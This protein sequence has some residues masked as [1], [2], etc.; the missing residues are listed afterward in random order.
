MEIR[1]KDEVTLK[2]MYSGFYKR[3]SPLK[4]MS[5]N[6]LGNF[7]GDVPVKCGQVAKHHIRLI[8]N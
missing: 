8:Y 3:K 4:T 6:I 5:T 7:Y 1:E 2:E